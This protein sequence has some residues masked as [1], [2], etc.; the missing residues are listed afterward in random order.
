MVDNK[1]VQWT[2]AA[3]F[4]EI[5]HDIVRRIVEDASRESTLRNL[6]EAIAEQNPARLQDLLIE[7]QMTPLY[8]L[9]LYLDGAIGPSEWPGAELVNAQTREPLTNDYGLALASIYRE[10]PETGR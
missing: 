10:A 1:Y 2:N 4:H 3:V 5:F 6:R 8:N 9:M 7:L